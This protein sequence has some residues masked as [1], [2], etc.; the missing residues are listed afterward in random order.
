M[1][2]FWQKRFLLV[3]ERENRTCISS[4]TT[5]LCPCFM[6]HLVYFIRKR[7]ENSISDL[8]HMV[9]NSALVLRAPWV[10][11]AICSTEYSKNFFVTLC[12]TRCKDV[13]LWYTLTRKLFGSIWWIQFQSLLTFSPSIYILCY[14]DENKESPT[15]IG[16]VINV[17]SIKKWM[18]SIY[19][20][21]STSTFSLFCGRKTEENIKFIKG[22]PAEYVRLSR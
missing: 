9:F 21:S 5:C 22:S 13:S 10:S 15:Q 6:L 1:S 16:D 12:Q 17:W 7:H 8:V 11:S 14:I 18:Q 19:M 20:W 4:C 2:C 3:H